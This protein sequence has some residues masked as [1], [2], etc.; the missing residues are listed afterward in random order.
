VAGT[1]ADGVSGPLRFL[2][3]RS[4]SIGRARVAVSAARDRRFGR[5][6]RDI[7]VLLIINILFYFALQN[8]I[9]I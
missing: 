4:A 8:I 3:F 5:A 2:R 6:L 9:Q 1:I 7:A